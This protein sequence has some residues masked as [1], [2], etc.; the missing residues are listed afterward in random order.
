MLP[1]ECDILSLKLTVE[2]LLHTSFEEEW[3][4]YL[5]KLDE[6]H[7]DV[8]LINEKHQK[9]MKNQYNKSIQPRSFTEGYLVLVYDPDHDK[10]RKGKLEPMWHVSY[11]IKCVVHKGT[12]ELVDYDGIYLGEPWNGI[13]LKKY[14]A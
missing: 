8:S 14:Y 3:F 12:Y 9:L 11:I 5:T 10:P 2:I 7:R 6:T 13:Y 1:I 4:L